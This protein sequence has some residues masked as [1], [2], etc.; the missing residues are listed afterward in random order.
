MAA[1]SQIRHLDLVKDV[2]EAINSTE[3]IPAAVDRHT[4]HGTRSGL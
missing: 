3:E 4:S 1:E 2:K